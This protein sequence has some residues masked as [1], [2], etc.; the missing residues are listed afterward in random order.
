M[1]TNNRLEEVNVK[2]TT[3]IEYIK[4][5]SITSLGGFPIIKE[6]T[7]SEVNEYM[8]EETIYDIDDFSIINGTNKDNIF[9]TINKSTTALINSENLEYYVP[10]QMSE[11]NKEDDVNIS[12]LLITDKHGFICNEEEIP[13][14]SELT[15]S[16]SAEIVLR[17]ERKWLEMIDHW[18][19]YMA[20]KFDIIKRRCR[21]GIPDSLRGRAWKHLCGAYFHMHIGKN[22]NVFDIV[23]QQPADPKY[24]EEIKKDL[25]RQFP[26]HELF[27]RQTPYGIREDGYCQAQAPIAAVLLMYMPLKEAFYC[28]VQ[29]CH[30]YLPGYFTHDMEQIKIDGEVMK[31]IMKAK[32]PKI[33]F[34]MKKNLVEPSMYLIQWFMCIF[35]RT[36][37][38]PSVLRIWDM[39]FCEGIKVLF[40]VA[41][42][43]ISETFGNKKTFEECPDQ[44]SILIKLKELSKELL[45]EDILVK[46]VL[47]I[48][49][50]EYDLER[51]H[52]RIVK[53]WKLRSDIYT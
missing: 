1:D 4:N 46:K 15:K 20:G 53:N 14:G 32:C 8:Q 42:V 6:E 36:L 23:S 39:F 21:K 3:S 5:Y 51:A 26:E 30:K 48:N 41:L 35:C 38:W 29:I 40:K 27:S 52:Y 7:H 12:T 28:F 47:D 2:P 50:D 44:G 34:H 11:D 16:L 17:R 37:P 10:E 31:H 45:S 43:I 22:K 24:V 33:Y 9:N 18:N 49:L 19:D 25:D 13:K